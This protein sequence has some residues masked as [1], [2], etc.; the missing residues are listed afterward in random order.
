MKLIK[1]QNKKRRRIYN[2]LSVIVGLT[3]MSIF[4]NLDIKFNKPFIAFIAAIISFSYTIYSIKRGSIEIEEIV[5]MEDSI[6]IYLFNKKKSP[7]VVP[8]EEISPL[9][10]DKDIKLMG[11]KTN[12]LIGIIVKGQ[13]MEQEDWDFLVN[14][15]WNK[16]A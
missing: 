11:K 15:H 1:L 8:L 6:K 7:M 13:L 10:S 16:K 14:Y 12:H 2:Y 4:L 3:L 9:K 5:F